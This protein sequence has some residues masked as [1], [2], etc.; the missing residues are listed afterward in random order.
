M[1]IQTREYFRVKSRLKLL[2]DI[3]AFIAKGEGV[4]KITGTTGVGKTALCRELAGQLE[5]SHYLVLNLSPPP[6]T[7]V[8]LEELLVRTLGLD[9]DANFL[10]AL[11]KLVCR[12]DPVKPLVLIV[13]DAECL[14]TSA[15]QVLR[16]FLN[17]HR[18]S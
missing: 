17:L 15:L 13:D 1:T 3:Q 7:A 2:G 8:A 16:S 18:N 14:E 9:Q 12:H 4:L 5:A 11:S 6:L 10:S